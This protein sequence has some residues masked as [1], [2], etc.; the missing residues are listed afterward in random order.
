MTD[1][2]VAGSGVAFG[3]AR[4]VCRFAV[5]PGNEALAHVDA[6]I[7]R[8]CMLGRAGG[9]RPHC[10][11]DHGQYGVTLPARR[12]GS[13]EVEALIGI[14][15]MQDAASQVLRNLLEAGGTPETAPQMAAAMVR[16]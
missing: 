12:R 11:S 3:T 13:N 15:A 2:V 6:C 16:A 7:E 10:D 4:L 8:F 14:D 9:F 5:T 1:L